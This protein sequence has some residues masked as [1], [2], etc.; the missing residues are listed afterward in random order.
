MTLENEFNEF[1]EEMQKR[2]GEKTSKKVTLERKFLLEKKKRQ[3]AT[4]SLSDLKVLT[5]LFVKY[6][7]L[8]VEVA[9]QKG[10]KIPNTI[11]RQVSL[12]LNASLEN[13]NERSLREL[14]VAQSILSEKLDEQ[15]NK[16]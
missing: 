10:I 9:K 5:D 8:Q 2:T 3:F 11:F 4:A 12:I 14:V 15:I 7:R 13:S 1:L 16:K 6:L